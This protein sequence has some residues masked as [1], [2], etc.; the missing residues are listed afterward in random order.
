MPRSGDC[1]VPQGLHEMGSHPKHPHAPHCQPGQLHALPLP[2]PPS[3]TMP[4]WSTMPPNSTARFLWVTSPN[5]VRALGAMPTRWHETAWVGCWPT[6]ALL[7]RLMPSA[8]MGYM[9]SMQLCKLPIQRPQPWCAP[10]FFT[11][12]KASVLRSSTHT[13]RGGRWQRRMGARRRSRLALADHGW[14][15]A[16]VHAK[17][18]QPHLQ[19][20]APTAEWVEPLTPRGSRPCPRPRPRPSCRAWA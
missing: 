15:G 2:S 6:R 10:C 16:H 12:S 1:V 9:T 4:S 5:A 14:R 18:R 19:G 7:L 3:P 8:M 17:P 20:P 13:L 11:R